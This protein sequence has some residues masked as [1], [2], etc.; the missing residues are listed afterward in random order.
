MRLARR[1]SATPVLVGARNAVDPETPSVRSATPQLT[2]FISATN[3]LHLVPWSATTM[4]PGSASHATR[5]AKVVRV[6]PILL[7]RTVILLFGNST[8]TGAT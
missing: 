5:N 8:S 6:I 4:P 7:A 2:F 1:T 3:A